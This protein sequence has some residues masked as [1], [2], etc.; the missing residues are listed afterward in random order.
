MDMEI[1]GFLVIVVHAQT[2]DTMVFG[3]VPI[4]QG[5]V[6]LNLTKQ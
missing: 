2:H 5:D 1:N 6:L 4:D 3:V